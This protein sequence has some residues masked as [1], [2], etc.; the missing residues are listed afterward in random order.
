MKSTVQCCVR[1]AIVLGAA[2]L[3]A[4]AQDADDDIVLEEVVVTAQK[5]EQSLRD[6][7][8]SVE[9]VLGDKLTDAGIVRLDE[10]TAY[11]P[12]LRMSETG[13]ANSIYI[14]GIGSGVNQGFEQSV[15]LY[16][17]GVYHGRGHQSRMPFLDLERI[18]VLRGPQPI[19]FG[20]NSVAGAVNT[21][22]RV[23]ASPRNDTFFPSGVQ[24]SR[25]AG[26]AGVKI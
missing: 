4:L 15:S 25:G 6:V 5:Q 2:P 14:R 12:N 9:A 20:K 8:L 10:L 3:A 11:V 19:L 7:P 17:D 26:N 21:C 13:I 1:L 18:E 23:P 22:G 24:R 16:Q